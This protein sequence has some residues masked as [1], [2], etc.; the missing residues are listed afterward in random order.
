MCKKTHFKTLNTSL[1][2]ACLDILIDDGF[3]S[4]YNIIN[5]KHIKVFMPYSDISDR[6]N[7]IIVFSSPKRV[8]L[9]TIKKLNSNYN[10][11]G[12]YILSTP[13]GIITDSGARNFNTGGLLLFG[14]F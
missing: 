1:N 13:H 11:G 9:V 2:K 3:I 12:F 6:L 10:D 5:N 4:S 8:T 7:W 14:I